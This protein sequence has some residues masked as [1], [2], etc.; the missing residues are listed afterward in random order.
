MSDEALISLAEAGRLLGGL[1]EKTVR[2]RIAAHVLPEPV[3]EGKFLRLFRSDVL[4]HIEQLKRRRN[5]RGDPCAVS[6]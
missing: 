3:K 6:S 4:A 5:N 2:R 1:C